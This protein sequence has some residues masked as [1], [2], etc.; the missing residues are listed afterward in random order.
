LSLDPN[1]KTHTDVSPQIVL[2]DPA[3]T[4]LNV[5]V[6]ITLGLLIKMNICH[7]AIGSAEHSSLESN[8]LL[9]V[10]G[11]L[12]HGKAYDAGITQ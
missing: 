11:M 5:I 4:G 6:Q 7:T 1:W 9:T 2:A 12:A 3:H 8:R 10:L